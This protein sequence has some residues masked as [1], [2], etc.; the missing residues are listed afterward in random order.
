M[1][2]SERITLKTRV[3]KQTKETY[4]SFKL[5][6]FSSKEKERERER[7]GERE[8]R[9]EKQNHTGSLKYR[10]FESEC[11]KSR[12]RGLIMFQYLSLSPT[13]FPLYLIFCFP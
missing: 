3:N 8:T 11:V 7:E 4:S 9:E 2:I 6:N 12:K 1:N 5:D 10:K 13:K